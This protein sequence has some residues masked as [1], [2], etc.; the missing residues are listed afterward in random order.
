[1]KGPGSSSSA[2]VPGPDRWLT[3]EVADALRRGRPRRRL[4][5]VRRPGARPAGPDQ[6]RQRQ[7]RRAGPG[8]V[9]PRPGPGRRAGGRGLRRRRRGV[10]DGRGGVR[11]RGGPRVRA[12]PDRRAARADRGAGRGRQGRGAAGRRLRR[13]LPV[14]PAQAVGG[15]RGPAAGGRRAPTWCWPSTTPPRA[16]GR[17]RSSRPRRSCSSTGRRRRRWWSAATSAATASRWSSPP[18]ATSTPTRIDMSCLLIVGSSATDRPG[19]VGLHAPRRLAHHRPERRQP[20]PRHLLAHREPVPGIEGQV[21]LLQ[22]LQIA[23]LPRRIRLGQDR[24]EQPAADALAL[25]AR[26]DARG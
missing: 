21:A 17:T 6:A 10:R 3:P 15:D 18:S 2:S 7:H 19:L 12:G 23:P 14:R 16:P 9:R 5:P 22:R 1:M 11:G 8:P 20:G 25:V 24:S 4:R 26:R 13:A